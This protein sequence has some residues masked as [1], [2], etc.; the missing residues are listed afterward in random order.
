MSRTPV[1]ANQLRISTKI[2]PRFNGLWGGV[3]GQP[4]SQLGLATANWTAQGQVHSIW[5]RDAKG[6]GWDANLKGG[7]PPPDVRVEREF[8]TSFLYY[9]LSVACSYRYQKSR[10]IEFSPKAD[11]LIYG[12]GDK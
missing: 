12:E 2:N 4:L 8:S 9:L 7:M 3:W 11:R 5:G 1:G 6:R 10:K